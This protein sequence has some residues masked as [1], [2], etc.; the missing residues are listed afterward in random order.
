[1]PDGTLEI[2]TFERGVEG[3]TLACG[4]GAVAAALVMAKPGRS[5]VFRLKSS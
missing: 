5:S 1:M 4:N 2:R 3:K